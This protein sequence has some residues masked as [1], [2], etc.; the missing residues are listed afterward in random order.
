MCNSIEYAYSMEHIFEILGDPA[1][2][3]RIESLAYNTWPGQMSAD[4]WCHQYDLQANQVVVSVAERGWDNN[5]WANIYGLEAHWTCCL[6]N[7]HHGW[8]RLV[9]SLWMATHDNGLFGAY[10]PCDVTAKVGQDGQ[11]VTITEETEYPFDGK[12]RMS[13]QSDGRCSSRCTC[14]SQPGRQ[15]PWSAGRPTAGGPTGDHPCAQPTMAAGRRGRTR[16]A[17]GPAC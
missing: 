12:I 15:G 5:A 14:G 13:V 9:K 17:D 3:D 16:P 11:R 7:K 2:G 4:M 8:P 6:A 1:A 10:G